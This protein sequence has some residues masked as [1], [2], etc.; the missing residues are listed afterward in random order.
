MSH[1]QLRITDLFLFT[2]NNKQ[3]TTNNQQQTTNNKQQT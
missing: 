2:T 3:P 1:Q